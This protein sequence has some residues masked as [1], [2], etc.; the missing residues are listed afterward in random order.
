MPRSTAPILPPTSVLNPAGGSIEASPSARSSPGSSW[1]SM[2]CGPAA[3]GG[4]GRADPNLQVADHLEPDNQHDVFWLVVWNGGGGIAEPEAV[5]EWMESDDGQDHSA[6]TPFALRWMHTTPPK[7]ARR[8]TVKVDV[9]LVHSD[10]RTLR[11]GSAAYVRHVRKVRPDGSPAS[12]TQPFV[13]G[14]TVRRDLCEEHYTRA[15]G[16]ERQRHHPSV[17]AQLVFADEVSRVELWL[18]D[19]QDRKQAHEC[20]HQSERQAHPN[21]R[22]LPS[23]SLW[24]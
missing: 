21:Q 4:R 1:R 24:V 12:P 7:L 2:S 23:H 14:R 11:L 5:V 15:E 6:I 16:A 10:G 13:S 19:M 20:G 3:S 18:E 17:A 22:G 8:A 9:V